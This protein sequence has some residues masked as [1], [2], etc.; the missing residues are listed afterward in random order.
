MKKY[1]TYQFT[2][3]MQAF[4]NYVCTINLFLLVVMNE[5]ILELL[6]KYMIQDKCYA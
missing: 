1:F 6:N 4:I 2:K 5:I 3:I